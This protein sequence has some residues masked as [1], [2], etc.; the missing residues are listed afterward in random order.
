MSARAK[1]DD[2]PS[3]WLIL[4]ED[5]LQFPAGWLAVRAR[6]AR[7]TLR[8]APT[9]LERTFYD[10]IGGYGSNNF[11]HGNP[12][13]RRAL[14]AALASADHVSV[15]PTGAALE[16]S[17]RLV[18]ACS[19]ASGRC[20]FTV[21]GSQAVE[22]ALRIGRLSAAKPGVA[23]VEGAFHGYG[24]ETVQLSKD[25]VPPELLAALPP[26]HGVTRLPWNDERALSQLAEA[27]PTTGVLLIEP[28]LGAAGFRLPDRRWFR[29]LL[30][31][32]RQEQVLTLIDEIQVGCGR[33]GRFLAVEH[34]L[35]SRAER[36]RLVDGVLL[37]KSIAGGVYPLSAVVLN[38]ER[39]RD[40]ESLDETAALGESFSNSPLGCAVGLAVL[41]LLEEDRGRLLKEAARRGAELVRA[42]RRA[43]SRPGAPGVRGLG[44]AIVLDYSNKSEAAEFVSRAWEEGVLCYVCGGRLFTCV[45]LIAPLTIAPAEFQDAAE[46]LSRA[47][48]PRG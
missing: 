41:D 44:M 33:T 2:S 15:F 43:A 39:V 29:A 1:S 46:R 42:L 37:S 16:L 13:I 40:I 10:F 8:H 45:K 7:V 48:G 35:P 32:A 11:G 21:G 36:R 5:R 6:G 47:M 20:Y 9:G 38:A 17:R 4:G 25:F 12:A 24:S 23:V 28:V 22:I 34:L 27:A 14:T 3:R 31:V 30:E 19:F 26:A 18:R